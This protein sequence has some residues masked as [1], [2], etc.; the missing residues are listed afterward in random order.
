MWLLWTFVLLLGSAL[1]KVGSSILATADL[2]RVAKKTGLPIVISPVDTRSAFWLITQ[3]Y[4]APIIRGAPFGLGSWAGFTTRGW[5]WEGHEKMH[6]KLGKVWV[7]VSPKRLDVYTADVDMINQVYARRKEFERDPEVKKYIPNLLQGSVSS[8]TGADWQ[9]HRRI[10]VPPFNEQN[11]GLVWAESLRQAAALCEW[12]TGHAQ[13]FNTSCVDTMTVALNVLATAGLGQSW[14]FTPA[15]SQHGKRPDSSGD[16]SADYRDTMAILLS[17]MRILS[18]MP[19]WLYSLDPMYVRLL[20]IPRAFRE[21]LIAAKHF[22]ML[23]RQMVEERRADF[24]AG[25]VKDNIF[26]NA[27]IAQSEASAVEKGLGLTETEIFGNMFGYGVAGHETTAHTLN[28]TLHLL[29]AYPEWQEWIQS[30]VDQ[31]YQEIP[32]DTERIDY[33][34]YFP[35]LNRCLA[36]MH[37]VLRLYPPVLEHNKQSLGSQ[38][39]DLRIDGREVHF[40]PDTVVHLNV[41]GC[42]LMSDYWGPDYREFKP[43]RWIKNDQASSEVFCQPTDDKGAFFPWSSGAR[44]CPGKKFSQVEYVAIMSYVLR[45]QRVE[46]IPLEGEM[47]EATRARVWENT[48]DSEPEVTMNMRN[49]EKVRLRLVSRAVAPVV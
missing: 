42:H 45:Y 9:R 18:L 23:M 46:A 1:Y 13:G 17:D 30:E 43:S 34:E 12:W 7:Q 20:P 33:A 37:E 27:M 28:Y 25:K 3:K 38:G 15:T 11:M 26:L 40:P 32:V 5:L 2:Y 22:K 41:I 14:R 4:I 6:Q 44:N 19:N 29:A 36:L 10:T 24:R 8:V 39:H 47:P 49:P 16:Y 48:K 21:H 31:V 35:R